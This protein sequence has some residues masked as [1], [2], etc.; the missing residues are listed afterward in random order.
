MASLKL[1]SLPYFFVLFNYLPKI[2]DGDI[3]TKG[4]PHR[5]SILFD[6]PNHPRYFMRTR[7]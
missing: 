5:L 7:A 3:L 2:K 6:I 4:C 1:Q